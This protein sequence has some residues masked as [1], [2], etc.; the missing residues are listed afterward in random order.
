MAHLDGPARTQ[1]WV[2]G[3]AHLVL[4][5]CACEELD[6]VRLSLQAEPA[7]SGPIVVDASTDPV[8]IHVIGICVGEDRRIADQLEQ[9]DAKD[10]NR[11]A[12]S[13][14]D[15]NA[16]RGVAD[17]DASTLEGK[18][19]LADGAERGYYRAGQSREVELELG[20][21]AGGRQVEVSVEVGGAADDRGA[22]TR[23]TRRGVV[24]GPQAQGGLESALKDQLPSVERGELFGGEAG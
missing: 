21:E 14:G 19:V 6:V 4:K 1:K 3:D 13:R 9:P 12:L 10:R 2:A 23:R 11:V 17:H 22:V 15:R 18:R 5:W 20:K 16:R 8:P 24:E 7:D